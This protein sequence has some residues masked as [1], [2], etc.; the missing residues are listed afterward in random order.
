MCAESVNQNA[1]PSPSPSPHSNKTHTSPPPLSP[2]QRPLRRRRGLPARD[3]VAVGQVRVRTG[4]IWDPPEDG[5]SDE[6]VEGWLSIATTGGKT[7]LTTLPE[8]APVETKVRKVAKDGQAAMDGVVVGAILISI[9]HE[10][11]E[12][13]EDLAVAQV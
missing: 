5:E 3:P 12:V 9:E 7:L 13:D 2:Q 11:D 6:K 10:I 1:H 4:P 8:G